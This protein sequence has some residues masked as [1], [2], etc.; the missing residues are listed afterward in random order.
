MKKR[1]FGILAALCLCLT[2]LPSTALAGSSTPV[3][4]NTWTELQT[5]INGNNDAILKSDIE[6]GGSSLTV[7][8]GK[9]VT[10]NLNA[11]S[12]D[13]KNKGTVIKVYGTLTLKN[14]GKDDLG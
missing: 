3:D 7:Q 13:A 8:A 4:V 11:H 14:S 10:I 2:L 1:F 6:W 5:A 9:N 12:I